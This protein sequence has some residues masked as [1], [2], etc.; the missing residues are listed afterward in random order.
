[1]TNVQEFEKLTQSSTKGVVL[2]SLG[3]FT[4]TATMPAAMKKGI[5]DAFHEFPE[6]TFIMKISLS[7]EDKALFAGY[8]NVHT[9]SW[10]DQI[11]LLSE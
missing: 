4:N 11:N 6:Y 8:R 2:F 1:M 10:I 3:S 5:L 9:F 7:D